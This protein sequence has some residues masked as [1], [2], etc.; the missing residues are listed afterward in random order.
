VSAAQAEAAFQRALELDDSCFE[1]W[2]NLGGVRMARLDFA[3]AVEANTRALA[4]K[5]DLVQAQFNLGL[6]HLYLGHPD[7]LVG[8]FE[9]VI[10][11]E[12][13]NA[14]GH[15]Y[16]AVGQLAQ[17]RVDDARASLQ[18]AQALGY[19]PPPEFLRALDKAEGSEGAIVMEFEPGKDPVQ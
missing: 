1:A 12:P 6:G 17:G 15:Y 16:L 5:P 19:Q 13:Q 9:K 4:V 11:A 7:E 18:R 10:A 8:C 2:V 14:A 3:G